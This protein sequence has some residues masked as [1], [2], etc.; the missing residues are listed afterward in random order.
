MRV[1]NYHCQILTERH[2]QAIWSHFMHLLLLLANTALNKKAATKNGQKNIIFIIANKLKLFGL[3]TEL[4]F[5]EL[6]KFYNLS[7]ACIIYF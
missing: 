7:K 5:L 3:I 4:C 1:A 6:L 2:E